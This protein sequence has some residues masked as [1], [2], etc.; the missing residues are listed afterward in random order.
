MAIPI[1]YNLR[2]L[3]V[4]KTTTLL[5][6][7]G[8]ALTVAV[9]LS[10]LALVS[11]LRAAFEATGNPLHLL[12]MRKGASSEL[13]SVVMR[14]TFQ[15]IKSHAGIARMPDGTP[16]ASLEMV[17]VI[18]LDDEAGETNVNLR[19]LTPVGIAMRGQ[20]RLAQGR[21]FSPGKREVVV[22]KAVAE[23]HPSARLGRKIFFGRGEWAVVGVMDGGRSAYNSEVFADLNLASADYQ[24]TEALSSVLIR[25][26]P[27]HLVALRRSLEDDRRLNALVQ[28]EKEYYAS[29]TTAAIPVQ[30]MGMLVAVIMAVGSSF[31]AMNTMFSAVARRAAE[32]GT[33]RVLGFSR[34]GILVSFLIESLL[35]ALAGGV[36]GCLLVLPLNNVTTGIGSFTSFSETAFHF[37]VSP[38]I[39]AAGVLFA[40]IIGAI[41]G[42]FP[43]R[44]AAKKEILSALRGA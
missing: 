27:E 17:T 26:E 21:W 36:A 23:R 4:R 24:R 13:M 5:T 39:M 44:E 19:A 38:A 10:V 9:L 8:I 30:F 7:L 12:V 31:A 37:Y 15:D 33:L 22:G 18:A 34:G 42:L 1:S 28:S 32:I 6:A 40:L 41:G 14:S 43:A 20:I 25:A 16:M 35:L 2:N 29:Q 11:G 3:A